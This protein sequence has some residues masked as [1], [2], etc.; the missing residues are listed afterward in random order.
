MSTDG[1]TI[2][3]LDTLNRLLGDIA[4]IGGP[5]TNVGAVVKDEVGHLLEACIRHTPGARTEVIE[6][7]VQYKERLLYSAYSGGDVGKD[8]R[9]QDRFI[10]QGQRNGNAWY[11]TENYTGRATAR[12]SRQRDR[13]GNVAKSWHL[14]N[15]NRRWP[16]ELWAEYQR[17]ES[18]RQQ[19]YA[20][21]LASEMRVAKRSKGL[22]AQS[23]LEIAD[24]LGIPIRIAEYVRRAIPSDGK[25]YVN[26]SG[27][28]ETT[29]EATSYVLENFQPL[30]LKS[31]KA[32]GIV[33]GAI[34]TRARAFDIAAQKGLFADL[35]FLAQRYPSLLK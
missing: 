2:E 35:A 17:E 19:D 33:S 34:A 25:S 24:A 16:D 5:E 23:W 20:A 8:A 26:G 7:R 12:F 29:A 18:E 14:M 32:A 22:S 6:Q 15:G 30:L 27:H 3:G 28:V 11:V 31:G 13:A 21:H 9:A 1:A 10:S 4:K